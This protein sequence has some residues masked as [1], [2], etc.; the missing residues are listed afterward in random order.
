[1]LSRQHVNGLLSLALSALPVLPLGGLSAFL[2]EVVKYSLM[3]VN[4]IH[5]WNKQPLSFF[6]PCLTLPLSIP[7]FYLFLSSVS[8]SLF[9]SLS[10]RDKLGPGSS[11]WA[12]PHKSSIRFH[13]AIFAKASLDSRVMITIKKVE[14][15]GKESRERKKKCRR[16]IN[17]NVLRCLPTI[18]LMQYLKSRFRI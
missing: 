6:H 12:G 5:S 9:H 8:L 10:L 11:K 2:L 15:S 14:R 13:R 1:M 18:N 4:E 7:F 17:R 16:Y 3:Y